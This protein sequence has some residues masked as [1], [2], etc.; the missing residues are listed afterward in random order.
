MNVDSVMYGGIE[1]ND[2]KKYYID[3]QV[4]IP[5]DLRYAKVIFMPIMDQSDIPLINDA[6][7]KV[8]HEASK[9]AFKYG[10]E[11]H[12]DYYY[13]IMCD[14]INHGCNPIGN[15]SVLIVMPYSTKNEELAKAELIR[16]VSEINMLCGIERSILYFNITTAIEVICN[17]SDENNKCRDTFESFEEIYHS[18]SKNISC[19]LD[20]TIEAASKLMQPAI[21]QNGKGREMTPSGVP[22][23]QAGAFFYSKA[24]MATKCKMFAA[25]TMQCNY[26]EVHEWINGDIF[27]KSIYNALTNSKLIFKN[28]TVL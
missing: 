5:K 26:S 21:D 24:V 10:Q 17:F 12:W 4:S 18:I 27:D 16:Y 11:D 14:T 13:G 23:I 20:S 19:D 15:P 8:K 28:Y 25:S 22:Y 9:V 6:Y 2:D 3:D 7:R 1:I